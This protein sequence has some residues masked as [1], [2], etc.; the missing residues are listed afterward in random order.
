MLTISHGL[1][2]YEQIH[3]RAS[4]AMH[5]DVNRRNCGCCPSRR[6]RRLDLQ[7]SDVQGA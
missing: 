3:L 7:S 1:Q 2:T 6:G 4:A 5:V